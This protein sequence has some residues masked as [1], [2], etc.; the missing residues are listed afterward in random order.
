MTLQA[1]V[2][3]ENYNLIPTPLFTA[4]AAFRRPIETFE[5]KPPLGSREYN[6]AATAAAHLQGPVSC[7][8]ILC[9]QMQPQKHTED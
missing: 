6:A 9:K 2:T 8:A 3:R 4:A 7:S 1:V 5:N